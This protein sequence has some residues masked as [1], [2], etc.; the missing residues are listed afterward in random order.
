MDAERPTDWL[1]ED[2][3]GRSTEERRDE[4]RRRATLALLEALAM[5][6]ATETQEGAR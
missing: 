1:A 5:P 6:P 3:C 2:V 4:F